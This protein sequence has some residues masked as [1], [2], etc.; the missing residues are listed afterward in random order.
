MKKREI[1]IFA[2][3][4]I[5]GIG[6]IGYAVS[7]RKAP[8]GVGGVTQEDYVKVVGTPE[9]DE[10]IFDERGKLTREAEE[11]FAKAVD[12][13]TSEV[14][15]FVHA[16]D[17][18]EAKEMPKVRVTLD[19]ELQKNL[20]KEKLKLVFEELLKQYGAKKTYT[21]QCETEDESK[22]TA[23]K[24]NPY[25]Y[26]IDNYKMVG[27]KEDVYYKQF[28]L[29]KQYDDGIRLERQ[30]YSQKIAL[31]E[32]KKIAEDFIRQLGGDYTIADSELWEI[33]QGNV[34]FEVDTG[35]EYSDADGGSG[36]GMNGYV[37]DAYFSVAGY[38]L[39]GNAAIRDADNPEIDGRDSCLQIVYA[40]CGLQYFSGQIMHR[41][42]ATNENDTNILGYQEAYDKMKQSYEAAKQGPSGGCH[43]ELQQAYL[44]YVWAGEEYLEP[45]WVFRGIESTILG[46][47]SEQPRNL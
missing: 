21:V 4:A 29:Y 31:Q 47:D 46:P 36:D 12:K 27:M 24:E 1:V 9:P 44:G 40:E 45:T 43:F 2:V 37:F 41:Y 7:Q 22:E 23:S 15:S 25:S 11:K 17:V 19:G 28:A 5:V 34:D 38:P 42:Q 18:Q 13:L 26:S 33:E 6:C 30:D 10:K 16:G 8:G 20:T 32:G 35:N 3:V 39:I 14:T